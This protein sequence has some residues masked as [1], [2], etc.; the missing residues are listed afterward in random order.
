MFKT[1][2]FIHLYNFVLFVLVKNV[3]RCNQASTNQ[4]K[5]NWNLPLVFSAALYNNY[6]IFIHQVTSDVQGQSMSRRSGGG[7]ADMMT[8]GKTFT[9]PEPATN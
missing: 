8:P 5:L 1:T 7:Y 4:H 2:A 3:L 9:R 6:T